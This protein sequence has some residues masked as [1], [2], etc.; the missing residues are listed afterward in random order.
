MNPRKI[1]ISHMD[2]RTIDDHRISVERP[3]IKEWNLLIREVRY[4]D[5]G[6]YECRINTKP[7]QI[8]KVTLSVQGAWRIAITVK[9]QFFFCI[10][11]MLDNRNSCCSLSLIHL[12]NHTLIRSLTHSLTHSL[13]RSLT[14]S[15]SLTYFHLLTHTFTHTRSHIYAPSYPLEHLLIHLR[16]RQSD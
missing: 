14:Y 15:N 13:A 8:K 4:N 1:L 7:K 6:T 16:G 10:I 5:S 9:R 3:Y 2:R 12:F 11:K